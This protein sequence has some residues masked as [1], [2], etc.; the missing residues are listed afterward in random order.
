LLIL[1][2]AAA[3]SFMKETDAGCAPLYIM[4]RAADKFRDMEGHLPAGPA[5]AAKLAVRT[6]QKKLKWEGEYDGVCVCSTTR[7]RCAS[8]S[9]FRAMMPRWQPTRPSCTSIAVFILSHVLIKILFCV[10]AARDGPE[11]SC[12]TLLPSWAA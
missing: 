3:L 6:Q 7:W 5:D 9:A 8:S 2:V 1:F 12:T 11:P 4:L 10:C